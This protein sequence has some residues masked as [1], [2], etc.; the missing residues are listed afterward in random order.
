MPKNNPKRSK[1]IVIGDRNL[2]KLKQDSTNAFKGKIGW[3]EQKIP[4]NRSE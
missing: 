4:L 2:T 3:I 1:Y